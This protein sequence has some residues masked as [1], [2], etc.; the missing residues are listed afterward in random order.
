MQRKYD[1]DKILFM[2]DRPHMQ[3]YLWAEAIDMIKID[4]LQNKN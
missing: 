3:K 4:I 1:L 2:I